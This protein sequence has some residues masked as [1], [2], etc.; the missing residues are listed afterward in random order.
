MRRIVQ[1]VEKNVPEEEE[2]EEEDDDDD[3]E[4]HFP[5]KRWKRL[6]KNIRVTG[7]FGGSRTTATWAD[8]DIAV[9]TIE[10]A[11]SLINSAIEECSIGDLGVVVLDELHML[12]DEHRGYLL[13][14]MATKLLLLQQDIQIVGMSATLSNT[15]MLAQWMNAKFYISTYRPVPIDEYLVYENSI[16]PAATSRQLFQ[17]ASKLTV[18]SSFLQDTILP[19]RIIEPSSFKELSNSATNSMIALAVETA[20][21]GFGALVFCGSR[22]ACQIHAA[23][24]SEAMPLPLAGS[25]EMS[26]RVDLI[27]ELRSLACGLDSVLQNT[28]IKGTGFHHAGMTTEERE[29]IAQAYDRGCL[30]PPAVLLLGSISPAR[31]VIIN[32]ARMGRELVGPAMLR[33]MCGRAGRKGKD[34]SG[35]TYL[36][37]VKADMEAVCDL[38]DADMP[39]IESCLAPEKRGLKRALLEAIAIGLVSGTEAIKEYVRCTLLYCTL[40][41]KIAY[42]IMKS[43]LQELIDEQLLL[44]RDDESYE[45]TLIGQAIVASAFS[46]EDGLFVHEELKQALQAF[47]MDGDMHIF[48]MFTP[49]QVAMS[50]PIDWQIF[51]SQL[52]HMDDSGLRALQ[53]VGVHPGFVN[54]MVQSGASLKET[55]PAQLKQGRIYRRAY[56]AF[57]LRDLSNEV[58]LSTIAQRY[59]IPRGTVQTLAQQCHGFAAGIVKF[60]QRMNWGMLAAVLDHMRDRLETGSRADLLEMAQVTFVKSWTARLLRDNGFKNLRALAEADPKDLVP[61]LMMVNPRKAQK[62][63]LYP[64]EA[65]KFAAKLLTK[66]E[67]IITS[68]NKIWDRELQVELEE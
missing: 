42:R 51:R 68:A 43:A 33:Q 46:P 20:A 55:T 48:Y 50:T 22:G 31:R 67:T 37:C 10:K 14:L 17:T 13:E 27:A 26:N 45:A 52:D 47:V 64:G 18:T 5:H 30:W 66:A 19:A 11:N 41:K 36:I 23:T 39:V 25:D 60:C 29:L 7:F 49:L 58:P 62:S 61:V 24:I 38:L 54:T 9:C 4:S 35:E 15:E 32:G 59:K 28:V 56:T 53:F 44:Y 3:H 34:E 40:D 12:D 2:E 63:Q 8:T 16:Y 1:D 65:E 57:Q 21:A 6:Q